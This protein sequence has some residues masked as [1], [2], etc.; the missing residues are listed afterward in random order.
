MAADIE[1]DVD[2]GEPRI[3]D[4]QHTLSFERA[5]PAIDELGSLRSTRAPGSLERR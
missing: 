5:V 1:V 4:D 2:L 3:T